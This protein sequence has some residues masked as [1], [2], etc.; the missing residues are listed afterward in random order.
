LLYL[1]AD[2]GITMN[3]DRVLADAKARALAMLAAG[4]GPPKPVELSLPGPT[5]RLILVKTVEGLMLAGKATAHDGVVSDGVAAVLSGGDD[6][7]ITRPL[8]E[9]DILD[10]EYQVFMALVK[11]PDSIDRIEHM[12]STGKPLR[13]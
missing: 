13:N 7:D 12:L 6:A 5:G 8:S 1:R 9:Q 4:Y 11:S 2:D 3:R 10:L